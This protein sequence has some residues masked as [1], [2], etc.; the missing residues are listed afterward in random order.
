[1]LEWLNCSLGISSLPSHWELRRLP[2]PS[3]S[4]PPPVA[5]VGEPYAFTFSSATFK[6]NGDTFRYTLGGAPAWLTLDADSRTLSGTPGA[7]DVG[8]TTPTIVA[9]D[10]TG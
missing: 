8:T 10:N 6:P 1:M 7:G 4:Q 2:F 5:R 3:N 9:M